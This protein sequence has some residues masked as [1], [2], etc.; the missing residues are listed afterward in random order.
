MLLLLAVAAEG[1]VGMFCWCM[2]CKRKKERWR[3]RG[4]N[5]PPIST[6][7]STRRPPTALPHNNTA[8]S[9]SLSLAE[10]RVVELTAV[11]V[12]VWRVVMIMRRR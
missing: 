11:A 5:R 6:S 9:S 7:F 3:E 12:T 4:E 10:V 8:T 2:M 1:I